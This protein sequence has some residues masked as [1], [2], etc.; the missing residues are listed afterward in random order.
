MAKRR[1]KKTKQGYLDG[2]E[3]PS[4]KEIDEAAEEFYDAK[5]ELKE[6]KE[7]SDGARD[8][9]VE[10]LQANQLETYKTP[11]GI[12]VSLKEGKSRVTAKK[13]TDG[14]DENEYVDDD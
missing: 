13:Q 14:G 3:P 10:L 1:R 4:I 2:I 8:K 12:L 5:L 9:L 7:K 11:E 6:L